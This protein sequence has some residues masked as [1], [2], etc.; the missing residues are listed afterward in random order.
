[1]NS[2]PQPACSPKAGVSCTARQLEVS[3]VSGITGAQ[4][5]QLRYISLSSTCLQARPGGQR[6]E[7]TM[8]FSSWK[9]V[10][11]TP[12]LCGVL[13]SR[14]RPAP[15]WELWAGRREPRALLSGHSLRR[16]PLRTR[17]EGWGE[18]SRENGHAGCWQ[19]PSTLSGLRRTDLMNS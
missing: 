17:S 18:R 12:A 6:T 11:K 5:A 14:V 8:W 9:R 16:G 10:A 3:E 2:V 1:M 15:A 4:G 19:V 13:P 7:S